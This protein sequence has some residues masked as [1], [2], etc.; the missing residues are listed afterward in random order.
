MNQEEE[1]VSTESVWA[2]ISLD[3]ISSGMQMNGTP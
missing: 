3:S 1:K 2:A